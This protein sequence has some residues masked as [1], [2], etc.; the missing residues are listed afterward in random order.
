MRVDLEQLR[1]HRNAL[2]ILRQRFLQDFLGLRI[3]AV[4]HVNVG[5]GDGVD[6]LALARDGS[7]SSCGGGCV[8]R[9]GAASG[10]GRPER[11][12][13]AERGSGSCRAKHAVL[14]LR[15][16]GPLA[17]PCDVAISEEEHD[18]A[19]EQPQIEGVIAKLVDDAR[20]GLRRALLR[21]GFR[22]FGLLRFRTGCRRLGGFDRR[23]SS[24]FGGF[25][26]GGLGSFDRRLRRR[27]RSRRSG[28]GGFGRRR[29]RL[30]GRRG[31]RS[32]C[33]S[34]RRRRLGGGLLL[35]LGKLLILHFEQLA[36]IGDVPL[37]VGLAR[38]RFLER[39]LACRC[40]V[41]ARG[42]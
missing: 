35:Q 33:R 2:R 20:F 29:S 23:R 36:Q 37:Q 6:F 22:R 32:R 41:L 28:L 30:G 11:R 24:R 1:L 8:G 27:R 4:G 3:A 21:I 16:R 38:L 39:S 19:E 31:R 34:G 12:R 7:T 26:G 14:E 5:F 9:R 25:G 13:R 18:Q 17:A 42:L 10:G 15:V 40:I